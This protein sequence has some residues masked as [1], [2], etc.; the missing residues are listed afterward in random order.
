MSHYADS[1]FLVSCYI[2]DA[3]TSQAQEYLSSLSTSLPWTLLH[4]LEVR[5]AFE[6]GVFRGH[7]STTNFSAVWASLEN[8]LRKGLLARTTVRW[9]NVFRSASRLSV[10]HTGTTGLGV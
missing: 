2:L 3:N 1:S 6:L 9:P 10:R 7:L 8:D 4:T 5:N